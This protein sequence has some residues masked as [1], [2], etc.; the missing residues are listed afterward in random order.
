MSESSNDHSSLGARGVLDDFVTWHSGGT[1]AKASPRYWSG[2]IPW[3]TPK[4]MKV[5]DLANTSDYLTSDGVA[6]GSKLAPASATYVVVRGMILAH[7]FPVSQMPR[8]A[9][10]NQD[11]KAVVPGSDLL[12]RY[13][14]YWFQGYAGDFLRLVGESTHGTKKLD[15]SDLRKFPMDLPSLAD[16][17]KILAIL[18]V[19]DDQITALGQIVRKFEQC[20]VGLV[21]DALR[22]DNFDQMKPLGLLADVRA[23]VTLGSEPS[24]PG[25]I[26]RPY[27]RVA[28][29]QDGH[30]DLSE[31][32]SVRVRKS[33][34]HRFELK[35]GDVLMNEGGD[36]DK[37]GRGAVWG[38]QIPGCLHQNHVFRVRCHL[39]ELTP[40]YLSLISGSAHGKRYFLSASKQT[41]NLATINSQQIK[42]F[43]VPL[44][45]LDR[46]LQI[47]EAVAVTTAK[48]EAERNCLAKAQLLKAGLMADLL[49]GRVRVPHESLS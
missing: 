22:E 20:R 40:Q 42:K 35:P 3:M 6:A 39:A 24:G 41:T 21:H 49:S 1:P 2:D 13:L 11:V 25:T 38:G 34:L 18:T 27:L 47:V 43:P 26:L 48:I 17:A 45:S 14:A 46:Q 31:I 19:L 32:K 30:L 16:Q 44:R 7:T 37:L 15:L 33:D 8:P 23:G 9:A 5:F 10:F 4:D 12:P 28:N 29:V 36:A